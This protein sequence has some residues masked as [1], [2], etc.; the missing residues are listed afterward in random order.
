MNFNAP[1]KLREHRQ[2]ICTQQ[3]DA[4]QNVEN[5]RQ[6]QADQESEQD[7]EQIEPEEITLMI[8]ET[9]T[10]ATKDNRGNN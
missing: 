5:A 1:N 8:E 4:A 6:D 3:S 2:Y 10:N 9:E 7:E